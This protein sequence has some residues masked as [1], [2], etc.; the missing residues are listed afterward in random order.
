M[1]NLYLLLIFSWHYTTAQIT[2]LQPGQYKPGF[3]SITHFDASRPAV[4]EQAVQDKGRIIQVNVWYPS[5]ANTKQISFA[6]YVHLIGKELDSSE[7][8]INWKQKGIDKYFSWPQ[9]AGADKKTFT[10]FLNEK[11]SMMAFINAKPL[12][13]KFPLILL[14]HGFAA[15]HAYLAE[16]IASNGYVVMHVPVKG[17]TEY[18]LDYAGK[19][20]ETQVLDYE[21]AL[22]VLSPAFASPN[23]KAVVAY[24]FGGQ[25]AVA[26]AIR[27]N[28]I[29]CIVSLDGGIG[30][31]FGARLLQQQP[32]YSTIKITQ[33]ILHL[34]N[35]ADEYTDLNW[36]GS[37]TASNRF[38]VPIKNM[39]HGYFTSFGLL[40]NVV[41]DILGAK[42]PDPGCAYETVMVMTKNFID[43]SL[44]NHTVL[45]E[46]FIQKQQE[47]YAWTKPYIGSATIM[48]A[49]T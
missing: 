26:L 41:P 20:L 38:L 39:D 46:Y 44:K 8:N 2:K 15:D 29:K 40:D 42:A 9:S 7:A 34:Y 21:F 27:N 36:F 28:S 17:T 22:S 5:I 1:K 6:D 32:Y 48:K 11:K 3:I 47:M 18:E 24:S 45:N 13:E 31:A 25:S 43:A 30:S 14:M 35:P 33:Q 19:G 23:V 4:K 10:D 49:G 16:Y 37:I 12:T